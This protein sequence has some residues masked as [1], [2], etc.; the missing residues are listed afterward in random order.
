MIT[1]TDCASTRTGCASVPAPYQSRTGW[2]RSACL[3]LRQR[4]IA[5]FPPSL[6][7]KTALRH[8]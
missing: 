6:F 4:S 2:S 8:S 7:M 1:R 3:A 5:R